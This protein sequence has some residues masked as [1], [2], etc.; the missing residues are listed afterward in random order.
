MTYISERQIPAVTQLVRELCIRLTAEDVAFA[1]LK[2]N[3]NFAA[4]LASAIDIDVLV[5]VG[6]KRHF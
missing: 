6:T 4:G 5:S 3:I 1:H 2:S